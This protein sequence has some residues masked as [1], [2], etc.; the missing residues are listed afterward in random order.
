MVCIQLYIIE[1]LYEGVDYQKTFSFDSE[2]SCKEFNK[3]Q[4]SIR[5]L[6]TEITEWRKVATPKPSDTIRERV[7]FSLEARK[8]VIKWLDECE[9]FWNRW[10][11]ELLPLDLRE[12]IS[13]AEE[14]IGRYR[15]SFGHDL[16]G[17]CIKQGGKFS[18]F[19]KHSFNNN[20]ELLPPSGH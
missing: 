11:K 8:M 6:A 4:K 14:E 5:D 20:L 19:D 12:S 7:M 15:T 10:G 1:D 9:M 13:E 17:M 16:G 2:E 3:G 18:W